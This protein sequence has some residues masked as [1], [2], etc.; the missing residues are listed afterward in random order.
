MRAAPRT[1]PSVRDYRTG[2]LPR[3]RASKRTLGQGCVMRTGGSHRV[4]RRFIRSQFRRVRWL[5]R[6]SARYQCHVAWVRKAFTAGLVG[7]VTSH[8][9]GQRMT[10]YSSLR[11]AA[12]SL[13]TMTPGQE[14][15][16]WRALFKSADTATRKAMV[17]I[18][19]SVV[20][21]PT[22]ADPKHRGLPVA[23]AALS[24]AI[25]DDRRATLSRYFGIPLGGAL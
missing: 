14:S 11:L 16:A 25:V 9:G 17:D 8:H 6:R 5:R 23:A 20:A 18:A 22:T 24:A 21:E 2:L 12:A 3:V 19:H 10:N 4:A 7:E 1:D 15:A 13:P